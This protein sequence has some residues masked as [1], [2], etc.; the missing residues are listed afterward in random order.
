LA[1]EAET[2]ISKVNPIE[3]ELVR[4]QVAQ[5]ILNLYKKYTNKKNYNIKKDN[6]ERLTLNGI[7]HK[8]IVSNAVVIKAKETLKL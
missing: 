6:N 1:L 2:A 7:R 3:Q 8:L 4:Y 5:N